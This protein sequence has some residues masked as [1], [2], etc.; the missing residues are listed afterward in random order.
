MP[1]SVRAH[2]TCWEAERRHGA[3]A[4][5]RLVREIIDWQLSDSDFLISKEVRV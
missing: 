4:W 5:I 3:K 1:V 2:R